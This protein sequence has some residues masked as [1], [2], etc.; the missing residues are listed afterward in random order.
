MLNPVSIRL[1]RNSLLFGFCVAL[2]AG[3]AG[4]E[5]TIQI[6]DDDPLPVPLA[7][8][9]VVAIDPATGNLTATTTD[10]FAC[11]QSDIN[12]KVSL[13]TADGSFFNINNSSSSLEILENSSVIINWAARGA[14]ECRGT[15]DLVG[16]TWNV[17][18]K[19]PFGSESVSL[20]GLT[21]GAYSVGLSCENGSV[22]SVLIDPVVIEIVPSGI[23]IPQGCLGRQPNNTTAATACRNGSASTDCSSYAS[24]FGGDFPG[25]QAGKEFFQPRGTYTAL[26]FDTN[27]LNANT[28]T[29]DFASPQFGSRTS[30]PRIITIS[31]CPGDFD[32]IKIDGEMGPGCYQ[33]TDPALGDLKWVRE[34]QTGGTCSLP[35]GG[36][37]YYNIFYTTQPAGTLPSEL[38]W[39]CGANS[40]AIQCENN[41]SPLF[42]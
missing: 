33:R 8:G 24:L 13:D 30:G 27:N 7:P 20:V 23:V 41:A 1:I 38:E 28:G 25:T 31:K 39:I 6:P 4:Q 36:E 26:R 37:F 3:I 5:L 32:K 17:S 9:S 15:G 34:G 21:P 11:L 14:W 40:T 29:L 16:T 19:L 12:C 2:A 18:G 22:E 10:E 42:Q 35:V